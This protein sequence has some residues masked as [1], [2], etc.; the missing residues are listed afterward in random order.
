M[1]SILICTVPIHGH[2]TPLLAVARYFVEQGH[3]VRF[4]TGSRFATTV[5][6]T[7]ARH[8]PLPGSADFDDRID[9]N[10]RFP[11]RAALSG[12]DAIAFDVLEL[13]TRPAMAQ[14]NAVVSAHA[15][16]PIDAM[17][18]DP[19]FAGASLVLG[20]SRDA[21]PAVVMCGV[22]PLSLA[23]CDTAPFGMGV[24]PMPGSIGRL[25]NKLLSALA[26]RVL[27]PAQR[28]A[29]DMHRQVF[30]VPMPGPILDW[31]R[32][33]EG[34]TQFTVPEFEYPRSDAPSTLHFVG[35]ISASGSSAPR[36]AWWRDLD[37]TRPVVHVTQGTIA[38]KDFNQ[39]IG[40]TLQALANEDV[41]VVVATGG[42][43]LTSLPPLPGNARAAEFLNYDELLPKT[44]V[45]VTNAGYG[46]VQYALRYGVPIVASG[47]LEDKPEV[48]AR[49]A[50]SGVGRRLR[51]VSPRPSEVRDAV[52]EILQDDRYR[53]AAAAMAERMACSGGLG[54][55]GSIVESVTSQA[56]RSGLKDYKTGFA[57]HPNQAQ[58]EN[59]A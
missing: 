26:A 36:P 3:S 32:R 35:P 4:L 5:R 19:A 53:R 28:H 56:A 6:E 54:A 25:R 9:L 13:F 39:L 47:G 8:I 41:I 55:L 48:G 37:G 10:D 57:I 29:D 59:A 34:I 31:A 42:R 21:R 24:P 52:R 22:L 44:D 14:Y 38:N 58:V 15:S 27:A 33:A 49:I 20:K 11:G 12:V 46:G 40:P 17:L 45:F 1:S 23:S 30:G 7:G 18:A 51:R 50:W 16:E 2:V 43:P